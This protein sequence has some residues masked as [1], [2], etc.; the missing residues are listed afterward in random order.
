M[1]RSRADR[2]SLKHAKMHLWG[3]DVPVGAI[4]E[5]GPYASCATPAFALLQLAPFVSQIHLCMLL[6]EVCGGFT[7][8]ELPGCVRDE[9]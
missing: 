5:C 4:G 9:L 6:H 3:G 2:W 1:V 7:V 8:C